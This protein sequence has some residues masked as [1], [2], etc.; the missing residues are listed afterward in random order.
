MLQQSLVGSLKPSCPGIMG[1]PHEGIWK[2]TSIQLA[3]PAG[4][5]CTLYTS[6]LLLIRS[7][8]TVSVTGYFSGPDGGGVSDRP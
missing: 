3:K 2:R 1:K 8:A 4:S 7:F 6:G 5:V